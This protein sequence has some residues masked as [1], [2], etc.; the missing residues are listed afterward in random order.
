MNILNKNETNSKMENPTHGFRETNLVLRVIQESQIKSKTV[1]S[2]NS[3]KKKKGA[4]F[5][6]FFFRRGFFKDLCFISMYSI[7][8]TLSEYNTF[9]YQKTLP[10]TLVLLFSKFVGSLQCILDEN[11]VK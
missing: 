2:W 8:D 5:A 10:H 7:L 1:I 3:R 4:F 11:Y 6:P 9:T